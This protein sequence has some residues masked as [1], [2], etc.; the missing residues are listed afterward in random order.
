MLTINNNGYDFTYSNGPNLLQV[1][2]F[3]PR[4]NLCILYFTRHFLTRS[5]DLYPPLNLIIS[6]SH[7]SLSPSPFQH[8]YQSAKLIWH[9]NMQMHRNSQQ[10]FKLQLQTPNISFWKEKNFCWPLELNP[11]T[12]S[13]KASVLSNKPQIK[14]ANLL[15]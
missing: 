15:I 13:P 5:S 2:V 10:N 9:R 6:L 12:L 11:D 1:C 8:R 4:E 3:G 14:T 7:S